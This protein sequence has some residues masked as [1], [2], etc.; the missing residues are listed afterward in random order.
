MTT[1]QAI[2]DTIITQIGGVNRLVSMIGAHSFIAAERAV[3]F[4][5]RARAKSGINCIEV[6][7]TADDLYTV[8]FIRRSRTRYDRVE[9]IDGIY[10]DML[11]G[12]IEQHTG[13][14][15]SLR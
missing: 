5:L 10:A 7:L 9:I 2:A 3:L 15:L 4:G 6:K 1:N 12:I 11:K 14:Y 13:L 8:T